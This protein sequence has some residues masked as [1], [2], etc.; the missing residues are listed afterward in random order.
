MACAE[1]GRGRIVVTSHDY[2]VIGSDVDGSST[3]DPV[4]RLQTN[5]KKWVAQDNVEVSELRVLST[6]E[7]VENL[8]GS[9]KVAAWYGGALSSDVTDDVIEFVMC[10][11]GLLYG[12]TPWG[13][14]QLNPGKTL[15]DMPMY[16]IL[17]MCGICYTPGYVDNGSGFDVENALVKNGGLHISNVKN[18]ATFKK[19]LP[20]SGLSMSELKRDLFGAAKWRREILGGVSFLPARGMPGGIVVYGDHSYP[21]LS[22]GVNENVLGC[23]HVGKGRIAVFSHDG[24]VGGIVSGDICMDVAT[25]HS[26]LKNWASNYKYKADSEIYVWEN[27][28]DVQ[29][30][31]EHKLVV[32]KWTGGSNEAA[33]QKVAEFVQDGGGLIAGMCPWGWMQLNPGKNLLDMPIYQSLTAG[34]MCFASDALSVGDINVSQALEEP[35]GGHHLGYSFDKTIETGELGSAAE[36]IAFGLRHLPDLAIQHLANKLHAFAE[37]YTAEIQACGPSPEAPASSAEQK[38]LMSLCEVLCQHNMGM[39]KVPGVEVFPGDFTSPPSVR[40]KP[41]RFESKRKEYHS[42]GYYLPAGAD[43]N[44]KVLSAEGSESWKIRVGAHT[45]VLYGQEEQRRWPNVCLEKPF[46]PLAGSTLTL[47]SPYGGLIYVKSPR[48]EAKLEVLMEGVVEAPHFDLTDPTSKQ[49]WASRRTAPGLWADIAGEYITITLPAQSVRDLEA[50]WDVM[51][52]WD[53]VVL[54]HHDLRGTHPSDGQRQF[55]VCDEQPSAGYMHSGHPIVTGLD[56]ADPTATGT[57]A[58]LLNNDALLSKGAW[59]MFHELGHNF[60]RDTWTF[61]GTGEVTCNIFTLHAMDVICGLDPWIHEW[62]AGALGR[63]NQYLQSAAG[64]PAWKADREQ[65]WP[66]ESMP[67]WLITLGGTRTRTYCASM[68]K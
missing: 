60:Q 68:K 14:L 25:L 41:M 5:M 21:I 55:V 44:V 13:W 54:A 29:L 11:G 28:T 51:S 39:S 24:Y 40:S 57:D 59:G 33:V 35:S 4:K 38:A 67:S 30:G 6:D 2:Y 37:V 23:G 31:P 1:L 18:D 58:F 8:Q 50:P 64:F 61:G 53:R 9:C 56:V 49:Q 62:L 12:M 32:W 42:T 20:N 52:T 47:R 66:L 63:I 19:L 10:G 46:A 16:S 34:G 36:V 17:K 43:V 3:E 22:S 7:N 15:A 48:G 26:N 27:Q 45:D 65:R